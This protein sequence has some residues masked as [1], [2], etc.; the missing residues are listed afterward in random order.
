MYLYAQKSHTEVI[1]SFIKLVLGDDL[2]IR[3]AH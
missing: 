3:Y 1:E 2:Y